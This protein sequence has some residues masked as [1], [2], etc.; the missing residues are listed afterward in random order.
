[1][2][3]GHDGGGGEEDEEDGDDDSGA[4]AEWAD[5]YGDVTTW[6]KA[7]RFRNLERKI[8]DSGGLI[9]VR[10]W[11]PTEVADGILRALR[12]LPAHLWNDT[13]ADRDHTNNNIGHRFDSTKGVTDHPDVTRAQ[14]TSLEHVRSVLRVFNSAVLP[15]RLASFSAAR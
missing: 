8:D 14:H 2:D 11:L 7:K 12:G 4:W 6:F 3:E 9:K 13:K 10:G 15:H 1:M 5:S